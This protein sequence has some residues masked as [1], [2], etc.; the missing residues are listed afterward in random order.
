VHAGSSL[1]CAD[2]KNWCLCLQNDPDH[3]NLPAWLHSHCHMSPALRLTTTLLSVAPPSPLP[4]NHLL[5]SICPTLLSITS[6]GLSTYTAQ[7][8]D[9]SM[10]FP[11]GPQQLG[12]FVGAAVSAGEGTGQHNRRLKR[13][14]Q[15]HLTLGL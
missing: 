13:L 7:L 4:Y 8:E 15:G 3:A 11:K 14:L 2:I 9:L 12:A 6:A 1:V 5:S 10:D